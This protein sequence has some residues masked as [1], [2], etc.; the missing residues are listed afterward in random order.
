MQRYYNDIK[1]FNTHK[2][3]RTW[4]CYALSISLRDIVP[5]KCLSCS[6][7]YLCINKYQNNSGEVF[8][9]FFYHVPYL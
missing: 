4:K 1:N 7:G 3:A 6:A 8:V 5:E 2:L 9:F